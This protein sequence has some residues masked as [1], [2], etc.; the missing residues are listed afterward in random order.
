VQ[1]WNRKEPRR[2]ERVPVGGGVRIGLDDDGRVVI[3]EDVARSVAT[4]VPWVEHVRRRAVLV[5]GP[6]G[7]AGVTLNGYRPLGAV[8]LEDRDEI[9][10]ARED[11]GEHARLV[12]TE[13][14]PARV[15]RFVRA[16]AGADD[17]VRCARCTRPLR[18]G[19]AVVPCPACSR[20]HHEG[21]LA[22]GG[23]SLC[24]S[25]DV[26]CGGCRASR[27]AM[28]WSPAAAEDGEEVE[29][30]RDGEDAT[31]GA[32]GGGR[33]AGSGRTPGPASTEEA[34]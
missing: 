19:D 6:G 21:P 34:A 16:S 12:F 15:V 32:V 3:G 17:E 22:S 30:A 33:D 29:E 26:E 8:V 5:S 10:I 13:L 1:L 23:E 4:I 11:A 9:R 31:D 24:F 28:M 14:E 7:E 18:S 2:W 25:Y 20:L 27:D